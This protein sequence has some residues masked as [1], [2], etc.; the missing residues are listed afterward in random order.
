MLSACLPNEKQPLRKLSQDEILSRLN[1]GDTQFQF[2]VIKDSLGNELSKELLKE[3]NAGKLTRDFY[4]DKADKVVEARARYLAKDEIL[5]EIQLRSAMTFPMK[6]FPFEEVDCENLQA[7]ISNSYERD[8]AVR[9][10]NSYTQKILEVDK[11][12]KILIVSIVEKCGWDAISDL[13]INEAFL[14]VQHNDSEIMARYYPKFY[15]YY[16]AG[17]LSNLN[18][19]R[20][21]DR[22]YMNCGF[23][24]IYGTQM[25]GKSFYQ[26]DDPANVNSRRDEL[27]LN[28][29][30]DLASKNGFEYNN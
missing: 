15:E 19:A 27:G 25:V 4:V 13:Q 26:I 14:I 10:G 11:L 29:I 20:M 12:N 16:Q 2:A 30:E 1:N 28:S 3:L 7:L 17:K 18:Y 22:L 24:Q 5:N 9:T 6:G 23:D 21:I 8:Q